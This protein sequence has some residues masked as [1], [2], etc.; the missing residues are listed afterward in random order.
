[1]DVAEKHRDSDFMSQHH[2]TMPNQPQRSRSMINLSSSHSFK[3]HSWLLPESRTVAEKQSQLTR[4][5]GL[6]GALSPPPP[7]TPSV[8]RY[9]EIFN[10][11]KAA[12]R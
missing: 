10:K 11:L 6:S 5:K 1:M 12:Y 2:S 8:K 3:R 9:L 7:K 4:R